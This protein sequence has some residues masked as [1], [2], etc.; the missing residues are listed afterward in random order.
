MLKFEVRGPPAPKFE[1]AA[2]R[3]QSR[4]LDLDSSL[5]VTSVESQTLSL[6]CQTQLRPERPS[7]FPPP[8]AGE[9]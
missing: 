4:V 8:P 5:R 7:D 9:H 2:A 1:W 6:Q 3:S